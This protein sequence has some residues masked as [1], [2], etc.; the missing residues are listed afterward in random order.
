MSPVHAAERFF[1]ILSDVK[2]E[3]KKN[4]NKPQQFS[5]LT[6]LEREC[7]GLLCKYLKETETIVFHNS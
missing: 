4:L 6:L 1:L 5:Q 2:E 7:E 3:K